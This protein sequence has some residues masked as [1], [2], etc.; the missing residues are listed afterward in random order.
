MRC[1]SIHHLAVNSAY[2]H[3]KI[4]DKKDFKINNQNQ[5]IKKCEYVFKKKNKTNSK[6]EGT[7]TA[8]KSNNQ[9]IHVTL[10]TL[11]FNN[12]LNKTGNVGGI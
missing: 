9:E 7:K 12:I 6:C 5:R 2:S 3:I 11:Q 8:S 4:L 10:M 1:K